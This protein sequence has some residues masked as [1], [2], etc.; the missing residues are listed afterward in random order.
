[1]FSRFILIFIFAINLHATSLPK[2]KHFGVE[3]NLFDI[4]TSG[5]SEEYLSGTISYF[6]HENNAEISFPIGYYKED[7]HDY[8]QYTFD[9]HYRK[10]IGDKMEGLYYSG[11]ARVAK[12]DG[13]S[14][15]YL[16]KQTKFGLGVGVGFR[17]FFE[18]GFYWGA[19]LGI[20]SYITGKNNQFVNDMFVI[21]DDPMFIFD[22]ELLKVGYSF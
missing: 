7:Y 3:V 11:F 5:S 17:I 4:I 21:T 2:D 20:G 15:N 22:L 14:G 6:D 18:N 12:L 10:F 13:I 9:L 8:K 16:I 19:S 1:M